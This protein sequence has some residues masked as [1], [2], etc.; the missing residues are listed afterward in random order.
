M[1]LL[2]LIAILGFVALIATTIVIALYAHK[3]SGTGAIK[4]IGEL[5]YVDTELAPVG[6]VIVSGE[7]WR[8]RSKDGNPLEAKSRIRVVAFADQLAVVE[9]CE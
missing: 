9:P 8:A 1:K 2:L 7:L 5:G 4:L 6:T 3:K